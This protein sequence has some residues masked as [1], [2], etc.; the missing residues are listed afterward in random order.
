MHKNTLGSFSFDVAKRILDILL[1]GNIGKTK[2]ALK[3]GLNYNTC[4]RYVR[5]LERLGWVTKDNSTVSITSLGRGISEKLISSD[6]P[7]LSNNI[8][9]NEKD[10]KSSSIQPSAVRSESQ[11]ESVK[12]LSQRRILRRRNEKTLQGHPKRMDKNDVTIMLVDDEPDVVLT[13]E[14]FL[15]SAGYNNV[16]VFSDSYE[17]L[18]SFIADPRRYDLVILDIRMENLNGLQLYQSFKATNPQVK[19]IFVSSLD[20][21]K[22][23]VSILPG[24]NIDKIIRKPTDKNKFIET[25]VSILTE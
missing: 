1:N 8:P 16:D 15:S 13:Y 11:Q 24:V 18:R 2:L 17:A 3:T 19:T 14:S 4:I 12:S 5:M 23:L 6:F 9:R 21:A 22:E 25:V 10:V 20:A 7:V